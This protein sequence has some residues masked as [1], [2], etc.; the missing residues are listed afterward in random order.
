MEDEAADESFVEDAPSE[1]RSLEPDSRPGV[2]IERDD[3]TCGS[4]KAEQ[5]MPVTVEWYQFFVHF[6]FLS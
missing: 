3:L 4:V 6:P 1:A 5:V 2:V